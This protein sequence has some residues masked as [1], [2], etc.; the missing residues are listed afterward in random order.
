MKIKEEFI[1]NLAAGL[2]E[3]CTQIDLLTAGTEDEGVD[4][5]LKYVEEPDE[6]LDKH[7]AAAEKLKAMEEADGDSWGTVKRVANKVWN[8]LKTGLFNAIAKF[9]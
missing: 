2:K 8:N 4:E 3:W 5:K 9:K 6:L 1:E 7:Y